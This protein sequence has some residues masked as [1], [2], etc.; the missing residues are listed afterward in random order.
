MNNYILIFILCILV[1]L[2]FCFP[3][4]LDSYDFKSKQMK[5]PFL[6]VFGVQKNNN[7]I[8]TNICF[9]TFPFLDPDQNEKEY[10]E[11]K[12]EGMQFLGCTS[13]S[14]FPGNITNKYDPLKD[15]DHPAWKFDYQNLVR[16]WL[17]VFRDPQKYITANLPMIRLA[18]S[19]FSDNSQFLVDSKKEKEFD[20]LYVCLKDND[21]CSPGWQS[22]IRSF[23]LVQKYLDI[24]C[25]KYNL[26][27]CLVGRIGCSVPELC[28]QHLTLTD[29]MPY[30]EFIKIYKKCKWT[31]IA[32]EKDA[33]PRVA[34]ESMLNNLPLFMNENILGG[35]QYI[36]EGET[37]EFFNE[38]N[39]EEQLELFLHN[40]SVYRA[41]DYYLEHF[42]KFNSGKKLKQ[43]CQS[44]FHESELNF[45]FNDVEYLVPD[46]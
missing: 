23:S 39:F 17:H 26:K 37:G 10:M 2:I 32:S 8:V 28:T 31:L 46:V 13:Y 29:F 1:S 24:M 27:G 20:F 22:E 44:I 5:R 38:E 3:K 43:F 11:A 16:G 33:S 35:W 12:K 7:R 9:I 19:D 6:N 15:K 34:S 25:Y 30:D 45:K 14:E 36:K 21:T 18:E 4:N 40:L 41:R 42:G